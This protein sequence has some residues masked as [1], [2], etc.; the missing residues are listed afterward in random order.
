MRP[1]FNP[2]PR[3][4][5]WLTGWTLLGLI[6]A[7]WPEWLPLWLSAGGVLLIIA[8]GDAVALYL[9]PPVRA[10]RF[11]APALPLGA[12]RPVRLRS[13]ICNHK[14]PRSPFLTTTRPAPPIAPISRKP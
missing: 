9:R 7:G 5:R 11:V 1:A 10:E 2:T 13:T 12:S 6:P 3:L 4:L 14:L 8:I